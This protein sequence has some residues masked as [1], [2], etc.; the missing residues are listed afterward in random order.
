MVNSNRDCLF[1]SRLLSAIISPR[2]NSV[3]E[4]ANNCDNFSI[5]SY[6]LSLGY[7][8]QTLS[9]CFIYYL[10]WYLL[11]HHSA[12]QI[13]MMYSKCLLYSFSI[14]FKTRWIFPQ[15]L[16]PVNI[17]SCMWVFD[18]ACNFFYLKLRYS[19]DSCINQLF[20]LTHEIYE[21]F[22]LGLEVRSAFLDILKA[23]DNVRHDDIIYKL[24]QNGI[25]GIY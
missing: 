17:V 12:G 14:K 11:F 13:I 3:S 6:S 24:T 23:F 2:I 21:S 8:S 15:T 22:D 20:S 10:A 7:I 16:G 18:I 25:L 4:H 5:H 9:S 19:G 1:L